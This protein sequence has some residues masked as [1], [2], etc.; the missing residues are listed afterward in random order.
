M[1]K[2]TG[3][4]DDIPSFAPRYT[5]CVI[6]QSINRFSPN[7]KG[8]E[9]M[10]RTVPFSSCFLSDLLSDDGKATPN[11]VDL[12]WDKD[13]AYLPFTS[14]TEG[15]SFGIVHTH[16]SLLS[17]IFSPEGAANHYLD[18]MMGD[19]LACGNWFFHVSGFY[20]VVLAACYGVTV[21]ALSEYSNTAFLEMVVE[22][23]TATATLYPWQVGY[24]SESNKKEGSTKV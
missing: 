16:R 21:Y 10:R 4:Q 17:W 12:I 2:M 22:T 14:A 1:M 18:Q 5:F 23:K 3:T 20:P 8:C 24:G 6:D 13:P 9:K 11:P 7:L 15:D 19:S